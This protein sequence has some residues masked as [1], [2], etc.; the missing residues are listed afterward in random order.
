MMPEPRGGA[1]WMSCEMDRY[2]T[3]KDFQRAIMDFA[4]LCGWFVYHTFDSR[5]SAAGFPDCI[6]VRQSRVVALE[7]KRESG[8]PT[9]AQLEW[10]AALDA[11]P[12]ITARVVK[13]SNWSEIE[14]LL[15]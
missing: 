4:T 2:V 8:K 5:D 15:R 12:G 6:F 7:V 1:R 3:E 9:A 13:P 10:I 14:R 11:V